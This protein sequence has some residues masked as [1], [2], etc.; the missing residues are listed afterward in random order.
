M[1]A[2]FQSH[3]HSVFVYNLPTVLQGNPSV[4]QNVHP[5]T[6]DIFIL[7][8]TNGTRRS[9]TDFQSLHPCAL[10]MTQYFAFTSPVATLQSTH[11]RYLSI[12]RPA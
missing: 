2:N 11:T 12:K 7:E 5:W 3:L 6:F 9:T 1:Q 4:T 8:H 10:H